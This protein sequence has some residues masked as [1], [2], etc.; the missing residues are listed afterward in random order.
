[1]V[2]T[3]FLEDG[4]DMLQVFSPGG[5]EDEDIIEKQRKNLSRNSL[6]TSFINT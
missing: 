4:T 5:A 2:F 6:R 3:Q 1:V